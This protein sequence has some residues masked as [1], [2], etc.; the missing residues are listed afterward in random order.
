MAQAQGD[1][2][3]DAGN[4]VVTR[5]PPAPVPTV[6]SYSG[7]TPKLVYWDICGLAQPIRLCLEAAGVA[8]EDVRIQP[9]EHG[10]PE[11]KQYWFS[12]KPSVGLPAP[13][14]PYLFDDDVAV[15]QSGAIIRHVGRKYGLVGDPSNFKRGALIDATIGQCEEF[16]SA[17][18]SMCYGGYNDG[19]KE[20]WVE[21]RMKPGL[22]IFARMLG[23]QTFFTGSEATIADFKV[24]EALDKSRIIE[25]GCLEAHPV[26]VAFT[27]RIEAIPNIA[28]YMASSRYQ[29]RPLNNPQ[30]QF[31]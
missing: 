10:T 9:G 6:Q 1:A 24:Y 2:S 12:A 17:L 11:Y 14:L 30:A 16:D 18:T 19:G 28:A 29:R 21:G 23:E 22:E 13:N 3:G 26:L 25:P 7:T 15:A 5:A 20:R 4:V 8:Y 31:K 27:A